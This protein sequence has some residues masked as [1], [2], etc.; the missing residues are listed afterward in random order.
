MKELLPRSLFEKNPELFRMNDKGERSP[1]SNCCVHSERAL[2][3]IAENAVTIAKDL[4]P[5]TGRYFY[6]G[7]DGQPW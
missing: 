5:T 3:I 6:W 7:D 2:E 1:D 4:Q